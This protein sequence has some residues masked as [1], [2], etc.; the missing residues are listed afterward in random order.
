MVVLTELYGHITSSD[1]GLVSRA[2]RHQTVETER[3]NFSKFLFDGVQTLYDCWVYGLHHAYS[4]GFVCLFSLV[5]IQ[6][7]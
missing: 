2:Q 6:G 4:V 5:Y 1:L 3:S 7:R